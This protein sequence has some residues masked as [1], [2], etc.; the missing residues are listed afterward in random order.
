VV[1]VPPL[2]IASNRLIKV[3][4]VAKNQRI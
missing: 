1:T 2:L 3:S 4:K